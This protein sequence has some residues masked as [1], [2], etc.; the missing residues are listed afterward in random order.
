MITPNPTIKPVRAVKKMALYARVST[1]EQTK[2]NYP[3]CDSQI[4][5]LA[6]EC[7]RRGW[8]AA[9]IIKD[10]GYSAGS[11][12]RPGLTEL[13]GLVQSGEV[14]GVVCTWYDR[15]TRSREF[16]VLDGEFRQHGV[17]FMTVHDPADTKTAAGRFMESMI[18]AAKTYE[19]EQTGEKVR[20]KMRQRAE[21][22]LWNGGHVPF[23]F[24]RESGAQVLTPNE[25]MKSV[26]HQVFQTYVDTQSD[27][28]VRDWLK[29][30]GIPASS[31][32]AD[33]TPS[34]I[35]ELL[36]SYRYVGE[37]EVNKHNRNV[38]N[39][40]E[41]DTYR[42]VSAPWQP[43][44][45]RELWER[46]QAVR[47]NRAEQSPNQNRGGKPN[48]KGIGQS[49]S[50]NQCGRVY[51]LQSNMV[52]GICGAAMSPHYVFHKA[53]GKEKRR[54]DSYVYHYTC[55]HK[56]KYRQAVTHSN[57]VLA[58]VAESWI[59]DAVDHYATSREA[60][61]RAL[62]IAQAHS[63]SNLHPMQ[64]AL[65]ECKA[66]LQRNQ[67]QIDD[68]VARVTSSRGALMELL[69]EKANALKAEREQLKAEQRHLTEKITPL[70]VRFDAD[71]FRGVLASF[72][73][74]REHAQPEEL[75][76]L[77]RLLVRRIEWM[78]DGTHQVQFCLPSS[79]GKHKK[80]GDNTSPP[81]FEPPTGRGANPQRNVEPVRTFRCGLFCILRLSASAFSSF[82]GGCCVQLMTKPCCCRMKRV[83]QPNAGAGWRY[84]RREK[85][86]HENSSHGPLRV[87]RLEVRC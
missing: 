56:M 15:I 20:T 63:E 28:A 68:L 3:S 23:G 14:N 21:K 66:A 65:T 49:Y 13:R 42:T 24:R 44:V 38:E 2:G 39:A 79:R 57:R 61:E 17:E 83:L 27:F 46:A 5:E 77:L 81:W 84:H 31:G 41:V 73:L 10:E 75:Q 59:L 32:K 45:P 19:R 43:F 50:R 55:A 34:S 52:C 74:L 47:R 25:S 37:I 35:R 82:C 4:E 53:G 69:E 36:M 86:G 33:W 18:V 60:M 12:K 6:A 80:G 87:C 7:Q 11:L 48:R 16:Y 85:A 72:A 64:E 22:G 78:P 1:D 40:S 67:E 29:A 8:Q 58:R 76:R 71:E 62:H 70:Q 51:L 54:T 26:V 9:H 30:H